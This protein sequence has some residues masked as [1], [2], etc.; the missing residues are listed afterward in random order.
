[1][2]EQEIPSSLISVKDVLGLS[3][4][5]TLLV[6]KISDAVVGI[7]GPW[8]M[9]RIAT[10]KAE[11]DVI[12][13][14]KKLQIADIKH[15]AMLRFEEEQIQYQ[16]NME[17]TV[18]KALPIVQDDAQPNKIEKDWLTHFFDK[19]RLVSDDQMQDVWARILA[20]EANSP[21]S[22]SKRAIN[23]LSE[24]SKQDA[25]MLNVLRQFCWEFDSRLV[26][27]VPDDTGFCNKHGLSLSCLRHLE[28]L[29]LISFSD[30][31]FGRDLPNPADGLVGTYFGRTVHLHHET[32]EGPD[33]G[34]GPQSISIGSGALTPSAHELL[35]LCDLNPVDGMWEHMLEQ[36]KHYSPKEVM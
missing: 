31:I 24:M 26:L 10:A 28:S 27:V 6:E 35:S 18:Q 4:P 8:Q 25:E 23:L 13:A 1:M 21:G 17:I 2:P 34:W 15:R 30:D 9:K 7:C 11:V 5:C 20:G 32:I 19:S 12:N 3:K 22:F 16:R 33:D 14:H 36:W 29:G